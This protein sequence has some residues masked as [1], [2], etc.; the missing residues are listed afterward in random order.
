[1]CVVCACASGDLSCFGG[2]VYEHLNRRESECRECVVEPCDL[3]SSV[4]RLELVLA[5]RC[6]VNQMSGYT[7]Q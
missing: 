2:G 1:M 3:V 6:Q 4:E 5:K 7:Y